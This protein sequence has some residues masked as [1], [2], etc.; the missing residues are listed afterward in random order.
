MNIRKYL[1][2]LLF[3]STF[4][5][6]SVFGSAAK[7]HEIHLPLVHFAHGQWHKTQTIAQNPE[8]DGTNANRNKDLM[9]K[10]IAITRSTSDKSLLN[11]EGQ[12]KNQSGQ[13][14]Y[15]Y[16][17]VAKFV[18]RNMT[19]EQAIIPV[20]STIEPGQ[21][22]LF[23]HEISTERLNSNSPE[24]VKPVVVKYEYR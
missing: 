23:T 15:V 8:A 21:S 9:V 24:S 14:H 2:V 10:S 22:T 12:I 4:W 18:S 16:Y 5:G 17:I 20:N 3:T 13:A 6:S 1:P 7:S 11:I 19:I